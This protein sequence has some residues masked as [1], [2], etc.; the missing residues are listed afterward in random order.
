MFFYSVDENSNEE[1]PED[2]DLLAHPGKFLRLKTARKRATM[3]CEGVKLVTTPIISYLVSWLFN[4]VGWSN[5]SDGFKYLG[6]MHDQ[7]FAYFLTNIF[8]SFVGYLL[9]IIVCSMA[10][11]KISFAFPITLMTPVSF[12]IAIGCEWLWSHDWLFDQKLPQVNYK[13]LAVACCVFFVAF[14]GQLLSTTYYIWRSQDFIMAK[15]SQLFWVP[16]YN[17]M[18]QCTRMIVASYMRFWKH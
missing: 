4:D 10:L 12:F 1:T 9:G 8:I 7:V 2:E 13:Q 11:Q 18:I 16:S 14:M 3:I 17:G 5:L 6:Q 15:E